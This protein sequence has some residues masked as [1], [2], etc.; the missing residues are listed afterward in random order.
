MFNTMSEQSNDRVMRFHIYRDFL[1]L[2]SAGW[3]NR[4]F[5]KVTGRQHTL[6]NLSEVSASQSV[7][8]RS[9]G[10]IR[11]VPIARIRGS[12]CKDFDTSFRPLNQVSLERWVSVAYAYQRGISLPIVELVQV[13]DL[14]YVRDGHHRISVA[15]WQGQKEIEA[16]VTVW[17]F[18]PA[19]GQPQSQAP[20]LTATNRR[21]M[22]GFAQIVIKARERM[23]ALFQKIQ[24]LANAR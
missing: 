11:S 7:F 17:H 1:R 10:G 24:P 15:C 18:R 12:R 3:R 8:I 6:L 5:T 20:G 23:I 9:H 13:D 21:P 19:E 14:Y 22:K 16:T 2:S 4:L